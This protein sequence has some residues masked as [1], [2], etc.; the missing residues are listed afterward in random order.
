MNVR[1]AS[2]GPAARLADTYSVGGVAIDVSATGEVAALLDSRLRFLRSPAAKPASVVFDIRTGDDDGF[3]VSPAG[4]G[5]PVYDAPGGRLMYFDGPDQLFIEYPGYFRM[6]CSPGTGLVQSAVLR[7]GAGSVLAAYLFFT[8][9][10]IE[11]MKRNGRFPIHAGCVAREGR[12]LLLAGMSGSGKSTLTAALVMD[13]W[14][15]LGDDMVFVAR[16]AGAALAWGLSDEIDCSDQTAG[17]FP[18]LRHLVGEPTLAGRGKHP[19]DV[20]EAF[21]VCPVPSCRPHA[22][23]LPAISGGRRSVLT[24]VSASHALRELAPNVL[25][26]QPAATQAHLDALAELVREV[27]CYSLATGTDLAFASRC[28]QEILG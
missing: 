17:M 21:G 4:P 1:S 20:E 14:D 28:L 7:E 25:L 16:Q 6:L 11:V 19:V 9:P 8:I 27:P 24:A 2:A 10:L 23:V 15:F 12:G 22:L 26:T 13:G 3:A 5:R 18:K